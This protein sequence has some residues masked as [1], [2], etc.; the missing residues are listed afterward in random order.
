MCENLRCRTCAS[1]K[2]GLVANVE[3]VFH[4]RVV[5]VGA[6]T[7]INY[8]ANNPVRAKGKIVA[9]YNREQ[10]LKQDLRRKDMDKQLDPN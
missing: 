9:L 5:P 8:I 3:T 2:Q 10:K 4:P 6:S 1:D 7:R